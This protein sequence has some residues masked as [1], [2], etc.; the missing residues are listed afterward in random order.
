VFNL[1]GSEVIIILVLALVVLGPE[2][3]PE[4]MRK[5][6]R[7]WAELRKMSTSFQDE[8]RKGFEEPA[9]EVRQTAK[10]VRSAATIGDTKVRYN[11][12]ADQPRALQGSSAAEPEADDAAQHADAQTP[13]AAEPATT[14]A[15]AVSSSDEAT[16]TAT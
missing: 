9:R 1:S 3:L 12:A 10:A 5:A 2:K 16:G 8:V 6:G 15:D 4:A 13:A 14:A 11:P 7:S